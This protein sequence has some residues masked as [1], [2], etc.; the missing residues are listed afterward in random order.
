MGLDSILRGAVSGTGAEVDAAGQLKVALPPSPVAAGWVRIAGPS[1]APLSITHTGH[2]IVG[3][4]SLLISDQVDGAALNTNLWSSTATTF[5]ITQASGLINLNAALSTAA[6]GAAQINSVKQIAMYG[7][8]S[9]AAAITAITNIAP[10]TNATIELGFGIASGT[11]A[12]TDGT[13]FRWSPGG[14]FVG[15]LNY[16][17]VETL[18]NPIV[19]PSINEA[20]EYIIIVDNR[21]VMFMI[22]GVAVATVFKAAAQPFPVSTARMPLFARVYNGAS[23]PSTA[24]RLQIGQTVVAQ[25]VLNVNR[26]WVATLAGIGR[27]AYQSPVTAFAQTPNHANSA[28]PAVATLSNTAASYA[29][30]GG[31]FLFNAIAGA[32]TDYALF[33]FQVPASYQLHVTDVS[34]SAMNMGA[35]VATAPTILDWSLGLNASAVSLATADGAGTWAPRRIPLGLQG[36]PLAAPKG[37]T[38]IGDSAPELTRHFSSPLVVDSGRFFHVILSVPVGAAT[39]S[40]QIRGDVVVTG[41]FE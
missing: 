12:P 14:N 20:H 38:Q 33:G 13:F 22:D 27:G 19:A 7:G 3:Q 36:F 1:G 34:I 35:A 10:Q 31:R 2:M 9:I 25:T 40:Q 24:P 37:P 29:T 30:L 15:V 11:A 23:S 5:T 17:G 8:H 21:K 16:G 32:A 6:N 39:A 4:D 28:A 26:D 18:S 41:Y